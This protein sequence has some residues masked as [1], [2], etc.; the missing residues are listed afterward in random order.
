MLKL[1][2]RRS[3]CIGGCGRLVLDG[4]CRKCRKT[5]LR[6]GLKRIKKLERQSKQKKG[7]E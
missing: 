3:L 2:K 1:F 4:E 7:G 6:Q 5:R